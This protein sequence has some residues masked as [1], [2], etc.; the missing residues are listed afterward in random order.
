MD[1]LKAR[2]R[3]GYSRSWVVKKYSLVGLWPSEVRL[4]RSFFSPGSR[5]LDIGCGGGRTSIPL[6]QAGY[7]VVALD[8]ATPMVA[9]THALA[10]F[11]NARIRGTVADAAVLPFPANT[12]D[13]ILFSYNGIELVP[14]QAGKRAVLAE[15]FRTLRPGGHFIFTTHAF[16]AFNQFARD[17]LH[18]A[19][20]QLIRTL[21]FQSHPEE[22]FGEIIP[23]PTS[24]VEVYYMQINSPRKYRRML[25]STGFGLRYF[26][27]RSRIDAQR[28]PGWLADFDAEFKFYVARKP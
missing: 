21:L 4:T 26:N 17:R 28:P 25:R 20:A 7:D 9:Q 15:A 16:E 14:R 11:T 2:V 10:E 18:R 5:L 6:A 13:G 24:N 1:S 27:S 22:E 12:F 8:L 3:H 19:L 23:D